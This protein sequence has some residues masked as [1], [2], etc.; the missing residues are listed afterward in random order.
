MRIIVSD[1]SC[2]IDLRKADLLSATMALPFTVQVALPLARD[3]LSSFGPEDWQR[4]TDLGLEIVD[5]D[6]ERVA[7]ALALM[8]LHRRLSAYDALSLALAEQ[9]R[10][11]ILLTSDGDLRRAGEALAIEVHGVLWVIDR[12]ADGQLLSNQELFTALTRLKADPL[13]FLPA[14]E[15]ET[16]LRRLGQP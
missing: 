1:T 4:L 14:E 15:V 8:R 11:C 7:R 10:D 16:R 12:I 5:L 3:E 6:G 2:L 9:Q 13:V